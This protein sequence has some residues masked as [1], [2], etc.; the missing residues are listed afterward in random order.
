MT[1]VSLL[2]IWPNV[3]GA[4]LYTRMIA[5]SGVSTSAVLTWKRMRNADRSIPLKAGVFTAPVK[6]VS[7]IR[8]I[9][10]LCVVITALK[11][12]STCRGRPD[13]C[14]SAEQRDRTQSTQSVDRPDPEIRV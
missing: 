5:L 10:W 12:R 11:R 14:T 8:R 4:K 1:D 9:H 13:C 6:T 3:E 7:W 2:V